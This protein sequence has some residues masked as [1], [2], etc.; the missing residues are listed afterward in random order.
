MII[1][2]IIIIIIINNSSYF[3]L[4]FFFFLFIQKH[5]YN[6]HIDKMKKSK[7]KIHIT[8]IK[9]KATI[10]TEIKLKEEQLQNQWIINGLKKKCRLL[11]EKRA[12]ELF[13]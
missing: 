3:Y 4:F 11:V 5:I 9:C 8:V 6:G 7:A 2:I 1:I 10:T 12:L 13:C